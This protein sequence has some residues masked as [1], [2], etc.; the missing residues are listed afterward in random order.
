MKT[1]LIYRLLALMFGVMTMIAC[2]KNGAMLP[3]NDQ[4]SAERFALDNSKLFGA[5]GGTVSPMRKGTTM[6]VSNAEFTSPTTSPD[7]DGNFYIADLQPGTYDL[8][9]NY[10]TYNG[11]GLILIDRVEVKTGLITNVGTIYLPSE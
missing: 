6:Y 7:D 8:Y 3:S 4:T 11:P 5:I 10:E 9:I 2:S 1:K